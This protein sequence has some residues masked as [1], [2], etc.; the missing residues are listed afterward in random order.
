MVAASQPGGVWPRRHL[1]RQA[2]GKAIPGNSSLGGGANPITDPGFETA[3]WTTG[4]VKISLIGD[5]G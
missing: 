4:D 5:C 3:L 2:P 1:H